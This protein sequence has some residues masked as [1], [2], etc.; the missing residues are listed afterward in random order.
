MDTTR[1]FS[2]S[3]IILPVLLVA[4]LIVGYFV[5]Q[6][7]FSSTSGELDTFSDKYLRDTKLGQEVDI[8]NKENISFNTNINNSVLAN[9][10][11]FSTII[12][13]SQSR[14]RSKPCLP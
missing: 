10:T 4:I 1:K 5:Y 3:N 14:G 8:I 13:P 11:E 6:G 7:F 2:I 9:G 12:S